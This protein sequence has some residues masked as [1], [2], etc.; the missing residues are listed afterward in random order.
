MNKTEL[1]EHLERLSHKSN[2]EWITSLNKR[3]LEELEFHNRDR[4]QESVR[5]MDEDTY[6]LLHGN[7]KFYNTV[8][9]VRQYTQ[10]WIQAHSKDKIFLDYACGNGGNAISAAKAGAALSIGLDISNISVMNARHF[11]SEQGVSANTYFLQGDCEN[12]GL[13]EECIDVCICSGML[14]HLDLSYAFYELRRIL[15]QGGDNSGN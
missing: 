9:L 3:K 11:A 13:P 12:T 8:H 5:K 15:K 4:D 7:K 6:E 14:H 2:E 10:N 1:L